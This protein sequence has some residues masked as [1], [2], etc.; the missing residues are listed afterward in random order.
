M[1]ISISSSFSMDDFFL[2]LFP[3]STWC[4]HSQPEM[5]CSSQSWV[6]AVVP[7]ASWEKLPPLELKT[8]VRAAACSVTSFVS[9]SCDPMDCSPSCSSVQGIL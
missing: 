7:K 2:K 3:P 5:G 4:L 9:D 8:Y 6:V 1:Q